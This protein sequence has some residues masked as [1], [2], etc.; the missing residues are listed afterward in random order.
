MQEVEF[1]ILN[2]IQQFCR[3]P[4]LDGPMVA[5]SAICNHGEVWIALAAVLLLF[6]RTRRAGLT[7]AAA[8]ILDLL[9]CNIVLKP[10]VQRIRP[11]D[12]NTAV[13]LLIARPLDY[14]FPS[15][16]AASSFTAVSA[17]KAAG[18][19]LW[20][21]AFVLAL[22]IC[23]SRLYLYVHWPSDILGGAVLG[24]LLGFLARRL[25]DR[26][27]RTIQNRHMGKMR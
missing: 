10:L 26:A 19:R 7:V 16:H 12:V 22:L 21:P 23:F 11:C 15:G 8:L 2:W 4:L 6:K 24:I 18:S 20:I 27:D 5:V 9:C 14:S 1:A 3:A 17:L 13:Q 25:M